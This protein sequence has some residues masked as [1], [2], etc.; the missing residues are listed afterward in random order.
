MKK[1]EKSE[2]GGFTANSLIIPLAAFLTAVIVCITL[3]TM[4]IHWTTIDLTDLMQRTNEYQRLS[5]NMQSG[6]MTL[7]GTATSFMN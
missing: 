1:K 3:L 4:N 7:S 2:I 5:E 6:A